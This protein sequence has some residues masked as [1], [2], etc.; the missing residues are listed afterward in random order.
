[1]KNLIE[2][3]I[4]WERLGRHP[5]SEY[6]FSIQRAVM[7]KKTGILTIDIRANF[8]MPYEDVLKIKAI[9]KNEVPAL[10]DVQLDFIYENVIQTKTEIISHFI[11]HM[12]AIVNGS[13]HGMTKT[14]I[15]DEFD[16]TGDIL[17]IFAVG[18]TVC[19]QLNKELGHTFEQMLSDNFGINCSVLF[20]NHKERYEETVNDICCMETEA[21]AKPYAPPAAK[22]QKPSNTKTAGNS[23]WRKKP[24]EK[25]IAEGN[26]IMGRNINSDVVPMLE[27]TQ[28]S[29]EVTIEGIVFKISDRT[30][31][32]GLKLV[33]IL[34]TDKKT[35][36]CV[37]SFVPD[38]KAAEIQEY[39]TPGTFAKIRGMAEWDTYDNVLIVKA[40]DIEKGEIKE[41][42][43]TWEDG[44]RVELH[45]HTKMSSMDGLNDAKEVVKQAIKWGHPAIAVTDHGVVQSFPDAAAAAGDKIKVI[46]GMEGYLLDDAGLIDEN[47][48]IDYKARGT[49][50][51]ILLA[52]TQEGLKNIYKLVSLSHLEY[53]YRR[54]RIPRSILEKHREGIII[55]A[56]CEAGE[57]YCGFKQGKS[58]EEIKKIA[59]FYDYLEI[60]P[61][62]NNRYLV[63]D[64]K[65]FQDNEALK[66]INRRIV[67]IAD[68]LGKLVCA[69]TD[70][71]Y[72]NPEDAIYRNI[73]FAGQG[74]KDA[75]SGEGLYFRTT[76]EMIKEFEYLGKE[77][78]VEVVITNT[79]AVADSIDDGILPV[80]KGKF[81]P[82]ID[83]AKETL[84]KACAE[85]LHEIYGDNVD[86]KIQARLRKELDSIIGNG[87]AVM[88]V[89]AQMLVNKSLSDGYLVGSRGSV[90]SSFAATMAGI[91]EVNPLPPHY[92]C[93]K[94][95]YLEWG[96]NKEY[97]CGVD[98]PEKNCPE[99]GTKMEQLGFT[100][101][102]ETFLGF[103]GDKE[104]D[105]DLN[106]AG[107]YQATAHK[108]V[109]EIFGEKNVFKAG[110]VGTVAEKTA[111][112]FVKKF[113]DERDIEVNKFEVERLA[114]N[115]TGVKRTTGQ[116]PGGIIIV[117]DDHEIYEFCPVQHPANDTSTDIVTTHFDYHKI[118][119][120]LLK[121]D[122]LGHDVPSM[123]RHL[124]DMTDVDPLKVQLKDEKVNSIFLNCDALD[125]KDPDYRFVHGSF[126]IPEFGTKFTRQMLDDTQPSR[127]GDLVRISGFSHGT[128]VW[129]NNAQE[130]IKNGDTTIKDAISTRDDIM[131]YLILK[132]LP[133]KEAFN[134][135]EKVRKGKGVT[136]ERVQLMKENNVPD[137]YIESCKRIKYMFPR[138][139]AVA[140]VMM[141]YRIAWFKVYY[142]VPFYAAYFTTKVA[143]FNSEVILKGS[144]AILTRID[145]ILAKGKN[146]TK[147]EE[148]EMTVLEV[149]YEMYS[150]GYEFA[151]ITFGISDGAKFYEHDGKVLL[152]F[153]AVS[154]IGETAAKALAD[155][156]K[157][158]PFETIEELKSRTKISNANIESLRAMGVLEGMPETDQL[159]MF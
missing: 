138:A 2:N 12:I 122:I 109:G 66:D 118:D 14:I 45:L 98:M 143:D 123:I 142:P 139:H 121:L 128:D 5:K 1:M 114:A 17:S 47:G 89:S 10:K 49:Y 80:P 92:V 100:I 40:K 85:K 153:M 8:V 110:T 65:I 60:Q 48:K 70:S 19:M 130:F 136:E 159:S 82:H 131:N 75:E 125:I 29:G 150:R 13:Y 95:K 137:W 97:D 81:P 16:L 50:H 86:P 126:G 111:F 147:K 54:P 158:C 108:Y 68:S 155:E 44:K 105:I 141:S 23:G 88:Y 93:P 34:V 37:K 94:C 87:Y 20:Q 61:L 26:R 28:E 116:H 38:E 104:P 42:K 72:T 76:D 74:Y 31:R 99:C 124:Q 117:P 39:L 30:I 149:A 101:P 106:F 84:E 79:N 56:A 62:I 115:C 57:V 157:K 67:S 64:V 59:E 120:N 107:E 148:D 6:E 41:R 21:A 51:I 145:G 53:F 32:E 71:H 18:Q 103:E 69:T 43:D 3:S 27:I 83:G 46:Y 11:E 55:G 96:D 144:N 24:R 63:E 15:T 52:K 129:I 127:F 135:M 140:Y 33:T 35:T 152:P 132:G 102:F 112:G 154:G 113:Y 78:A 7:S 25:D 73:L 134:I 77:R 133:N 36:M 146:A 151:P 156:C 22:P 90:G 9:V 4:S 119:Q 91:T 58:D